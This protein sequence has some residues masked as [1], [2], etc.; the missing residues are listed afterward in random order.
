MTL[1][2]P[3]LRKSLL[4]CCCLALLT[5]LAG[6]SAGADKKDADKE[7]FTFV[8]ITDSHIFDSG[9]PRK[10]QTPQQLRANVVEITDS[11]AAWD[12][13]LLEINRLAVARPL[14]FVA[15]TGDFGLEKVTTTDPPPLGCIA[16]SSALDDTARAFSGLLVDKVYVVRGNNDLD[17][18]N[19]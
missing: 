9:K 14:D 10:N 15:F 6:A 13:A 2:S 16:R 18:E 19:P 4:R 7:S 1:R 17:E 12:W 5:C 11:R 8:Q 3:V